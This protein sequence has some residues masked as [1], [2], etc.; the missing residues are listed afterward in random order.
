MNSMFYGAKAFKGD[1]SKWQVGEVTDIY[2]MFGKASVFNSDISKWDVRKVK[3]MSY[4]FK[5]ATSFSQTLCGHWDAST[6][7]GKASMFAGSKGKIC[8]YGKECL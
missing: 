8:P 1:I 6:A 3:K 2:S 4:T 7:T 5:E